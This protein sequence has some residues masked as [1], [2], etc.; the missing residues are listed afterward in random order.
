VTVEATAHL[1][2]KVEGYTRRVRV[3]R[4]LREDKARADLGFLVH[5]VAR[6]AHEAARRPD[7]LMVQLDG[8]PR[9]DGPT[10]RELCRLVAPAK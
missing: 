3:G 5:A 9:V 1:S 10:L 7:W 4:S 8:C 2:V 6:V